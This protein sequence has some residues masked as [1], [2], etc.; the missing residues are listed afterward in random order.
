M[1]APLTEPLEIPDLPG[2][3]RDPDRIAWEPFRDGVRVHWLYR[4]APDG[5]AAAFLRYEP[6]A[7]VPTHLHA[8]YEHIT[9]L[10]GSQSDARGTY[11]AGSLVINPPGTRHAVASAEGCLVLIVW[12]RPVVIGG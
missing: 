1:T 5:P 3:A 6:G 7:A 11:P 4:T 2:L 9:V 12:E 10:A 8:G